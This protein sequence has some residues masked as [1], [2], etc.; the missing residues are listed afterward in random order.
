MAFSLRRDRPGW[1]TPLVIHGCE[2]CSMFAYA[3]VAVAKHGKLLSPVSVPLL[4]LARLR[5]G[6]GDGSCDAYHPDAI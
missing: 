5:Q 6:D 2:N 1:A 4:Q 3:A